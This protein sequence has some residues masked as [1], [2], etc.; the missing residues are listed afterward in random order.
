[1]LFSILNFK[2]DVL[3][4]FL[5][6]VF[7][8]TTSTKGHKNDLL[9]LSLNGTRPFATFSTKG[10]HHR[11][12]SIQKIYNGLYSQLLQFINDVENDTLNDDTFN[13][14]LNYIEDALYYLEF[15]SILTTFDRDSK[16]SCYYTETL[17]RLQTLHDQKDP[18]LLIDILKQFR[19]N[20]LIELDENIQRAYGS[21]KNELQQMWHD[22]EDDWDDNTISEDEYED[23]SNHIHG[24]EIE[25]E[26]RLHLRD[27]QDDKVCKDT[28]YQRFTNLKKIIIEN[29]LQNHMPMNLL[30]DTE[31]LLKGHT[32]DTDEMLK[33]INDETKK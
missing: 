19:T 5:P 30:R 3:L 13:E 16:R 25:F 6:R 29:N 12:L 28:L 31:R 27:L 20:L 4:H 33:N 14:H 26:F 22:L 18:A 24:K 15:H 1:M 7:T 10:H 32:N 11:L 8:V 9:N 2:N 17:F 21:K 23:R